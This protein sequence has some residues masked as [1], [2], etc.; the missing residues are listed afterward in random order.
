M[1]IYDGDLLLAAALFIGFV[2][3]VFLGITAIDVSGYFKRREPH[4]AASS[5]APKT[6]VIIPCRGT[7]VTLGDNLASL[8]SQDYGG[9]KV[10]AVVD[11]DGD[12]A[13]PFIKKA[14]LDYIIA[15]S[16]CTR[17]SGKVRA[18]STAL[19]RF[20]DYDAYVIA[21]SDILVKKDWLSL[22]IAPLGDKS[23][24]LS[25]TFPFFNPLGGF[26][27]NVKMVW[28]FVGD[29]LMETKATRFGWGGS[30]AFRKDLLD[31]GGLDFFRDSEYSVSDDVA[32]TKLVKGR[33][34]G[35]AYV[36]GA[37]PLVNSDDDFARLSEWSNRQTAFSI[38]GYRAN[39]YYGIAFYSAEILL[40]ASGIALALLVSPIFIL[41]L[42][43]FAQSLAR[44][45]SRAKRAYASLAL[46]TIFM[47][48]FY[49]AN[50]LVASGKKTVV[51]R[52]RQYTLKS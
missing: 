11:S 49:L 32:I 34:L 35:L 47:P 24:G 39:L 3:L 13:V 20:K 45:C 38:M 16:K 50:L 41:F 14:K 2:T 5:Y 12:A 40:F 22:L 23:I 44:N 29:G 17:C 43:H 19:E 6:L 10:I 1:T 30:L 31:D 27:T 9:Y 15:S 8:A 33:K 48:F 26:W 4:A 21:D 42:L 7:D 25:T 36:R 51:W 46:I 37:K 52:G 28:G 18:V